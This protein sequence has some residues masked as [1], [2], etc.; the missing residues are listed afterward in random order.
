MSNLIINSLD[1]QRWYNEKYHWHRDDGP[2][3]I[4]DNGYY[5]AWYIN[6]KFHQTDGPARTWNKCNTE[7]EYCINN[8]WYT[9]NNSFQEA[10]GISNE[11]MIAMI[12]KYGNVK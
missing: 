8:Q 2:A 11:D 3:V 7:H 9:D 1:D 5:T 12:L 10:A 6:G 4:L